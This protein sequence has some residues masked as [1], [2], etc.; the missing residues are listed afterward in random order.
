MGLAKFVCIYDDE[1]NML[2]SEKTTK[3][4]DVN[5]IPSCFK[6]EEKLYIDGIN[7]D[8]EK[9]NE[10]F[11][12]EIIEQKPVVPSKVFLEVYERAFNS[13]YMAVIVLCPHRKWFGYYNEAKTAQRQ[14][15]RHKK[16]SAENFRIYV[17]DT[18]TFASGAMIQGIWGAKLYAEKSC[19]SEYIANLIK[20][21]CNKS[22]TF[23][24]SLKNEIFS[25]YMVTGTRVTQLDISDSVDSVKF[26]KFAETVSRYI[27]NASGLYSVSVGF[28]CDFAGS[29]LGRIEEKTKI[30]PQAVSQYGIPTT[31]ILGTKAICIHLL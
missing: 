5:F 3:L 31:D 14:F 29:V 28:H 10:I 20:A 18:K 17:I 8:S 2:F 4:Y 9:Y 27:K 26:T 13:G 7:A 21:K 15:S 25:A 23:I 24:L 16:Y 1:K 11:N 22:R 6:S 19:S 12:K 30:L